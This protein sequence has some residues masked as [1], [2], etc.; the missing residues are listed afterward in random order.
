MGLVSNL[1][2]LVPLPKPGAQTEPLLLSP[3]SGMELL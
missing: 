3:V 2:E 1:L